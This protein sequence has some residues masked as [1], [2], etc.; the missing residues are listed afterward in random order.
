MR[1]GWRLGTAG[2]VVAL[3]LSALPGGSAFAR[4][5]VPVPE[6][7]RMMCLD[8]P[9]EC[10]G[11]GAAIVPYSDTLMRLIRRTNRKVNAAIAPRPDELMDVWTINAKVGDCEEYVLAKRDALIAAG[12]PASAL[13]IV[14]ALHHGG[15]HAIL[16]INTD[17]GSFVLDNR[18][19][20]IKRLDQTGYKLVS[21]SGPNPLIWH[22]A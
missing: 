19:A 15:G 12:V 10:R 20:A 3:S 22:R 4:T 1:N 13:S 17:K 16:A 11:G 7:F 5:S 18:T 8:H 21:M 6:G 14:Y 2:L 9:A